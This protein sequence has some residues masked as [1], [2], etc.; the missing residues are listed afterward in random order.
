MGYIGKYGSKDVA[1]EFHCSHY[2]TPSWSGL[3]ESKVTPEIERDI[4]AFVSIEARRKGNNDCV[5]NCLNE[6]LA[7][8][9]P[10]YLG[11]WVHEMWL[12][13]YKLG[14]EEAKQRLGR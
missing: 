9:H 3:H 2:G 7:F 8:F 12:E 13:H 5:Q 10:E 4:K 1:P 6:N 11:G 14:V